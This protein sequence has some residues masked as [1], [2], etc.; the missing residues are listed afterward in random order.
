MNTAQALLKAM[1]STI[2]GLTWLVLV[3]LMIPGF[4]LC[5]TRLHRRLAK[6]LILGG[7]RSP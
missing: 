6:D 3:T 7:V 2:I 4:Y 5:F 1:K